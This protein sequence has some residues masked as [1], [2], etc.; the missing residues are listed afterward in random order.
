MSNK[1]NDTSLA[2]TLQ[3]APGDT[4]P[5]K[6]PEVVR[7]VT[8]QE[9]TGQTSVQS[10]TKFT[11]DSNKVVND[12]DYDVH[13]SDLI[14][15]MN[16]TQATEQ[17]LLDFLS[18][19]VIISSGN[20]STTDTYSFLNTQLMPSAAF[21]ATQAIVWREK[22]RG[23]FGIRMD[24][25]FKIVVNANRF[26]QGRYCLGWVPLAGADSNLSNLKTLYYVS[27][28]HLSTIVQRTTVR[29]VEFDLNQDTTAELTIPWC[30][31]KSYYP[32]NNVTSS[33]T[34]GELGAL[35]LYPYVPMSS[36]AGST[37]ASYTIYCSLTNIHLVGAASPQSGGPK[38]TRAVNKSADSELSNTLNGPVSGPARKFGQFASAVATLPIPYLSEVATGVGWIAEG[39]ACVASAFGY[40]KPSQGDSQVKFQLL[41]AP[42]NANVDGDSDARSLAYQTKPG[43]NMVYGIANTEYDEMAFSYIS[44][45]YSNYVI[46]TWPTSNLA[47]SVLFDM[48]IRLSSYVRSTA[49]SVV[50]HSPVAFVGS[51]FNYWRGSL[52]VRIKFVKT[53]FHS[54]R[55]SIAHFPADAV[56]NNVGNQAYVNREIIDIREHNEVEL[57]IP[58]IH[59]TMWASYTDLI[60]TL[61]ISVVDRLVAPDTVS[62]SVS[63]LVEV[64]GGDDFDVAVPS[65]ALDWIPLGIVPQSGLPTN[66]DKIVASDIGNSS[67]TGDYF[68]AS[69]LAIG[70]H[71]T[72]FRALLKRFHPISP[73]NVALAST[74]KLNRKVLRFY[75]DSVN[76]LS[77]TPSTDHILPDKFSTIASCYSIYRGGYVIRDVIDTGL[78]E[79][80]AGR[81]SPAMVVAG[82][83]E[84]PNDYT[85]P[86]LTATTGVITNNA[87]PKVYQDISLNP[88]VTLEIPQYSSSIGR[89]MVDIMNFDGGAATFRYN[90]RSTSSSTGMAVQVALPD[91]AVP[92][93]TAPD[94]A[95]QS[96]HHVSRILADD[97]SFHGF[98]SIPPMVQRSATNSFSLL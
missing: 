14:T 4:I 54:G 77:A 91:A 28:T 49:G 26:Q 23:Y 70:D 50:H 12:T 76:V 33:T 27:N 42:N 36:P 74:E 66:V 2:T 94:V 37:I 35:S 20:F 93:G 62:P 79:T 85:N 38:R 63:Y 61:R 24:M 31:V 41:Q 22:L 96:L 8:V 53:E 11:E 69:A 97:G 52:K 90:A 30:S 57:I 60:G 89:S 72:N 65:N 21:A 13:I 17:S 64:C 48:P 92:S 44:R 68:S 59:D 15:R 73:S 43:V 55:I 88:V 81:Q 6:D 9:A 10:T 16:D 18:K 46:L 71:V 3:S 47:D 25:K 56:A 34:Y 80:V 45:I 86:C 1:T 78:V 7:D 39:V 95:L 19:P 58:F 98:V 84:S 51:F 40:S 32:L 82:L 83:T 67:V 87:L 29:R 5:S 75:G